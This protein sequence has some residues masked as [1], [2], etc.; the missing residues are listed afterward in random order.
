M[1][2]IKILNRLFGWSRQICGS[3]DC[4]NTFIY[5]FQ[6][7]GF[8][9]YWLFAQYA[10]Y[11]CYRTYKTDKICH[12]HSFAKHDSA[13]MSRNWFSFTYCPS[14]SLGI[15]INCVKQ[16]PYLN[17]TNSKWFCFMY[18]IYRM[19]IYKYLCKRKIKNCETKTHVNKNSQIS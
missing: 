13:H 11:S 1:V 12:F 10:H 18:I 7:L 5:T 19:N 15:Y 8:T 2:R 3:I 14:S 17:V 6:A 16:F 4:S 9:P